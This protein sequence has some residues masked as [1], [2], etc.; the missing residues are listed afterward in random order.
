MQPSALA[1]IKVI[2]FGQYIAGPLAAMLLGDFGA[3]VIRV[4]PPGGPRFDTAANATW[5]RNKRSIVLDLKQPADVEIAKRLI[6]SADVV[7]E[8]FRP[9]VMERLGLGARDMSAENPRLVYVSI[10][11]FASGDP[12]SAMQAWE[13]VVGAA[14]GCYSTN[15]ILK[16]TRPVYNCLPFSSLFGAHWAA[17]AAAVA[18]NERARSGQGQIIE[19]PLFNATFSAFSGKAMKVHGQPEKEALSTW[20]HVLCKDGKWFLYVPRDV[21]K[22]LMKEHGFDIPPG[23]IH[24]PEV[25]QR[26]DEIFLKRTAKEW[27]AYCAEKEVEGC[28]CITTLEWMQHP[29]AR[30]SGV[31]QDY[32]DPI[33]GKFTGLGMHVR[34]S[35]TPAQVRLAR[36]KPDTHR[37]EI[38]AELES[39]RA[40]PPVKQNEV[41][42]SALQGALQ[43]IKVLDLGIILAIP[44][45][46][47]TLAE[48]GADV[49]KIDSPHR[50]P[51]PW[52]N[53]INRAKRSI[54]LDLKS[55]E[56]RDIFWRLL[57][58][59]DVV[60]ENFR[61][62]VADKLGIGYEAARARRPD[63]V[64][65]SVNAYGQTKGYVTRP[66]REVL[67]QALTGMQT[68]YGGAKPAQNPLNGCDYIT[69]LGVCFGVALALLHR[70]RT[71]QGQYVNGALIYSGTLLQS[72]LLQHY[73]GKQWDEP[74]G[75]DS[76]GRGPLYRAYQTQDDWLF[77]AA[78]KEDLSRCAQ[79]S[80]CAGMYGSA[81]EQALEA[82]FRERLA[83]EWEALLFA[84]GIAAQRV[85]MNFGPLMED[86]L[87]IRQGLSITRPHDHQG[88]ITTS[89]P[90]IRLSRT[91]MTP[92][93]PTPMPGTD[94]ESILRDVG[95]AGE[96]ERLVAQGIVVTS[97]VEPGGA[98]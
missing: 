15:P 36:A 44:S 14:T 27:E 24:A 95:M 83:A 47:R 48:F 81:L 69:G 72:S 63:I 42:H 94:A 39:K 56:G 65:C 89:G 77:I 98:S 35:E 82:R 33:L 52:H 55:E 96:L 3:D 29:L 30:D 26:A 70:Q 41:M 49:I 37:R 19:A 51:V 80:D 85:A 34:L 90:G 5:N 23:S 75:I 62:G 53:D 22:M 54:L 43:G 17:V 20:R 4:E 68:R 2:D 6:R 11:G 57:D 92:G 16:L 71:G 59:A 91:P 64:Y 45:C 76:L 66:G 73:E 38:L 60:L 12:R 50:N 32:E 87:A 31:V 1:G 58:D 84:A 18:L 7:I 74:G 10:P 78:R 40:A 93:R 21:H 88:M 46:G 28:A 86:P 8:N 67:I 79:L 13:G 9:G 97:G 25:L 61:T